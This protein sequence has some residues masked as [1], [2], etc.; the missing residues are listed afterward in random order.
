MAATVIISSAASGASLLPCF[1]DSK[2]LQLQVGVQ[3]SFAI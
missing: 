2:H 1:A 3:G